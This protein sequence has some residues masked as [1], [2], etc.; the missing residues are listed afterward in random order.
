MVGRLPIGINV[1]REYFVKIPVRVS[2]E[3]VNQVLRPKLEERR[4][5]VIN[6]FSSASEGMQNE[7]RTMQAVRCLASYHALQ[8]SYPVQKL[9]ERMV[10]RMKEAGLGFGGHFVAVDLRLDRLQEREC[11]SSVAYLSGKSPLLKKKCLWPSEVGLLLQNL[12]FDPNTA[13][14]VTQSRWDKLLDPLSDLFPNLHTKVCDLSAIF[15]L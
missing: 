3:Y 2:P 15:A 4:V 12:G 11:N 14:Y 9:G 8:F 10:N 6:S 5:I 1:T 7:D 13:V